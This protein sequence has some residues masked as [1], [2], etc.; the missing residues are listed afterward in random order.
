MGCENLNS[1]INPQASPKRSWVTCCRPQQ[2]LEPPHNARPLAYRPIYLTLQ[3]CGSTKILK[4]EI[5]K[6]RE[7]KDPARQFTGRL[8]AL[9]RPVS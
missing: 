3:I 7:K 8:T 6:R 4:N 5:K 2:P 1:L 9:P